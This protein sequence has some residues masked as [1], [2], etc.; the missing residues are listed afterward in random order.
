MQFSVRP[1][2]PGDAEAVAE[3]LCD[4]RREFL[5]YAPMVHA[6]QEVRHWVADVLLPAG[7]VFVA[8][9]TKLVIAMVAIAQKDG[10]GWID[11]LYV[12]PGFTAQGIGAELLRFAHG[13]LK[14]PIRL[15]T[16][17]ANAGA[18]RFYERHGYR[19]IEFADGS[20]NEERCPDV[21]YEW[22][23]AGAAANST[24]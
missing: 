22:H 1:A 6:P 8:V 5:S 17:Q 15:C 9:H 16:F 23:G 20:G 24:L 11:H 14:P 21:L 2:K 7:G 4:S 3:V 10:V 12:R 19:P 18:R 13:V